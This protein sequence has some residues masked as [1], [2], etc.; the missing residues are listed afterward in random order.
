MTKSSLT[1]LVSATFIWQY[2]RWYLLDLFLLQ[3]NTSQ[4]NTLLLGM[5]GFIII[6]FW[7]VEIFLTIFHSRSL[8]INYKVYLQNNI[9]N[10]YFQKQSSIIIESL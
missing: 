4:W 2:L 1:N 3:F 9:P 8:L 10:G 5:N 7:S 6:L